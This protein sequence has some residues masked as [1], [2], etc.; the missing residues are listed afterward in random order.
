MATIKIERKGKV[1]TQIKA[2]EKW[3]VAV[4]EAMQ[5]EQIAKDFLASG[6]S[7]DSYFVSSST[8][9]VVLSMAGYLQTSLEGVGR[10]PGTMPPVSAI[11]DWV[12][13]K[14]IAT[15]EKSIRSIAWAISIKL[16]DDGNQV[17]QRKREGIDLENIIL[18]SFNEV[19]DDIGM[20][21]AIDAADKLVTLFEYGKVKK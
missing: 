18:E 15:D 8:K 9:S 10:K 7:L 3:A 14:G 5:A 1:T 12:E 17:Y 13:L 6:E 20:Q 2:L 4:G 11:A 19:A 16:R 21:V